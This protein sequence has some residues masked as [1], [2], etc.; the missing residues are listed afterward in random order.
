MNK[1]SCL[2]ASIYLSLSVLCGADWPQWRGSDRLGVSQE[3]GLLKSWPSV[4]PKLLWTGGEVGEGFSSLAIV[5][6]HI[7]TMGDKAGQSYLFCLNQ[8]GGAIR[9]SLKVGKSGGNYSGTRCTP[10]VDGDLVFALGQFGDLVC[11]EFASGREIWRKNLANDFGGS[12]GG[13]N[14]SESV[15]VDGN[16]VICSPGGK[17]ATALA[18]NKRTGSTVWKT[19]LPG[20]GESHYSSWVISNGAGVKQYVRLFAGG[21]FGV[22]AANGK[23]L[24]RYDKLGS[25]TA[26]IP[27]PIPF[28]DYVFTAAGYGKGGALLKLSRN[29]G[30]VAAE[31]IYFKR[32]LK[33]KHGG[34]VK[35]GNYVYGDFDDRGSPWC[36]DIRTGEVKWRRDGGGQGSGSACVTY[37]DGRLYF[38]YQDGIMGLVDASPQGGFQQISSFKIPDGMKKSWSHP[39]ISSGLLYLR[40]LNKI[41][42][43]DIRDHVQA[44][45]PTSVTRLWTDSSGQFKVEAALQGVQ[46]GE[47]ILKKSDGS[48]LKISLDRLSSGDQA[49]LR[50]L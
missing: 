13:W 34:I 47:A 44:A 40:G 14:Y 42:C 19:A 28:G 26:N 32:E 25:N 21:T 1:L 45:A 5:N 4:G 35:A 7:F 16:N 2:L 11:V 31:E 50:S 10:T 49:F 15:L 41:L 33:N 39:V 3:S 22:A 46:K 48:V 23:F 38:R 12:S 43:Y 29:R 30:G 18:L 37:A 20:G 6:G 8:K 9:W 24:W 27:T 36:A 17:H